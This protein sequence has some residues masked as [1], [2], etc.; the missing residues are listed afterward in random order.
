[1]ILE[2]NIAVD[3]NQTQNKNIG[4]K[5]RSGMRQRTYEPSGLDI[6]PYHKKKL[7]PP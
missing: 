3:V 2:H 1:M 5:R 7:T 4:H 6:D